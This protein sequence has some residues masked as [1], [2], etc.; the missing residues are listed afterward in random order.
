MQ[1]FSR[2]FFIIVLSVG[3]IGADTSTA[4]AA[5][6]RCPTPP[7][8]QKVID[9]LL[10]NFLPDTA[11]LARYLAPRLVLVDTAYTIES[12]PACLT[13]E[14]Y[15]AF[16]ALDAAMKKDIGTGVFVRSG[17]RSY[18][19]QVR[20]LKATPTLA[21]LP[22]KSEH[23][24]GTAIDFSHTN[25]QEREDFFY[26]TPQYQ[27]MTQHAYRFGFVETYG[28]W[29]ST[30]SP[31]EPWHWR[32][33]GVAAATEIFETGDDPLGYLNRRVLVQLR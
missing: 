15:T 8:R 19:T 21:A 14:T 20:V 26:T 27:W 12:R 23:Q 11:T 17:W 31:W 33:V 13:K 2:T 6:V 9:G 10:F 28:E 22:G 18:E 3:I 32:Y 25:T 1:Y 29:N 7:K 5:S 16:L 24:L 4:I 30:E